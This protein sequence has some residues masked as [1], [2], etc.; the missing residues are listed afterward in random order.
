MAKAKQV[1]PDSKPLDE[2]TQTELKR[3]AT[4]RLRRLN[5]A[6]KAAVIGDAIGAPVTGPL[7]VLL[8]SFV[9]VLLSAWPSV[10]SLVRKSRQ[11]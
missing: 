7:Q 5:S 3:G 6:A 1:N 9:S 11:S 2:Q 10:L 8:P 4:A